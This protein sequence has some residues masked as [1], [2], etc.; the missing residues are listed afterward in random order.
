MMSINGQLVTILIK[1]TKTMN[2]KKRQLS[3]NIGQFKL[4]VK[5]RLKEN[6]TTTI[7]K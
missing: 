4:K 5:D 7:S 1:Y 6:K 2:Y 3:E